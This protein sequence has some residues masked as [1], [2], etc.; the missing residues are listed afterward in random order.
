M[1]YS[2]LL[3]YSIQP[4]SGPLKLGLRG[5]Y[6]FWVTQDGGIIETEDHTSTCLEMF[7]EFT[8]VPGYEEDEEVFNDAGHNAMFH[9]FDLGW[10][11]IIAH[12]DKSI[13][14]SKTD[15]GIEGY[16]SGKVS[17]AAIKAIRYLVNNLPEYAYYRCDDHG[18]YR[19]KAEFL[20]FLG[21]VRL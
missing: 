18:M 17:K 10:V 15:F 8:K 3:E 19:T 14:M 2:E 6:G 5:V 12:M 13:D 11:R 21:S 4:S 7:P 20:R 16:Q 1:R 9:A